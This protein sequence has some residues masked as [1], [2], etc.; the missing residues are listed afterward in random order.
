MRAS[1]YVL[2]AVLCI[3]A[4]ALAA[5][6]VSREDRA[7]ELFRRSEQ[8]YR[9]G[10]CREAAA[11]LRDAHRLH[12]AP[13]LLYNLARALECEADL[14]GALDAYQRY[15]GAE[16]T[17]ANRAAVERR[18]EGLRHQLR[19]R[20]ALDR[21]RSDADRARRQA[22]VRLQTILR[23]P[24]PTRPRARALPWVVTASGAALLAVGAVLGAVALSRHRSAV[25]APGQTEA[26]DLQA[27]ASQLALG[28]DVTLGAGGLLAAG[29]LIWGILDVRAAR[30]E[31]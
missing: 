23:S 9:V 18:V 5:P 4:S 28:A 25:A 8:L 19:D 6:A 12:P 2:S 27:E 14:S 3:G 7:R 29:G 15:L 17:A 30:G 26:A 21:A 20:E 10:Q 16:P 13:L 11:L 24:P 22:E 31:P 1:F